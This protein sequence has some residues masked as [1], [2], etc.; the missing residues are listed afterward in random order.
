MA[1]SPTSIRSHDELLVFQQLA[2]V[3]L[4]RGSSATF[5]AAPPSQPAPRGAK[6]RRRAAVAS[7]APR[8]AQ[9]LLVEDAD[10]VLHW[11]YEPAGTAAAGV[12]GPGLAAARRAVLRNRYRGGLFGGTRIVASAEAADVGPNRITDALQK[13]DLQLTPDPGLRVLQG[14]VLHKPG[15]APAQLAGASRVLLLVHGTFSCGDMY[16]RELAA[17]E[18]AQGQQFIDNL[19]GRYSHVVSFDHPTLSVSPMLNAI[20]LENALTAA[21]LAEA[22]PVDVVCHSR[23]GLV[24]TWWLLNTRF[25]AERV[26]SVAAP[27]VGTSLASPYRVRLLLDYLANY[28]KFLSRGLKTAATVPTFASGFLAGAGGLVG[29]LGSV[30]SAVASLPI[31]D[32]GI[33]LVP[34]LHAMSRVTNNAEI[35]RLWDANRFARAA[36][37]VRFHVIGA[38]YEPADNSPWWNLW[39][40]FKQLPWN[41]ADA[42]TDKLFPGGNDLVVDTDS[43]GANLGAPAARVHMFAKKEGVHHCA[44]FGHAVAVTK[45]RAWLQV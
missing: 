32:A 44:Y 7:A 13:L 28:A 11:E 10:G 15:D 2:A 1:T 20:D 3:N 18:F 5:A 4:A 34:G 41:A 31:A 26:V 9:V 42:V 25:K 22:T 40:K 30:T 24:T 17:P 35:H 37:N 39:A 14:R 21:G 8:T 6:L 27:L 33:A 23:G 45:L 12:R 29:V 43:M 19:P 36:A 38:D 16:V